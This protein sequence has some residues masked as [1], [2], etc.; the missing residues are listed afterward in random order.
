MKCDWQSFLRLLPQRMRM[1]VDTI[2]KESLQEIRLRAGQ[3]PELVLGNSR[4]YL[5]EVVCNTDLDF[6]INAASQYSPWSASTV[7]NG[8]ITSHGGH[9]IGICGQMVL[10]QGKVLTARNITSLCIRVARD[11][12]G[13]AT[14]AAG[15]RGSILIVGSPGRGKTTLLRDLIRQK[16]NLESV[17]VAVVDERCELFPFNNGI[18]SFSPG[19]QTDILSGCSKYNG[20]EMLIKT[21]NPDYVAVDEITALEDCNAIIHA[22]GCGV[23]I[24]ATAHAGDMHDLQKRPVYKPILDSGIF[25]NIIVMNPDKTWKLERVNR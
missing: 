6:C 15:L 3:V 20:M 13:I 5:N 19:K 14:H 10:L 21:M 18:F 9:R 8:Y 25:Q 17:N 24:L 1:K 2:G 7:A 16:S 23:S 4:T 22:N 12:P 11:Y